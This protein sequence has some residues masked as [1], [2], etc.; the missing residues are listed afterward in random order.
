MIFRISELSLIAFS[1]IELRNSNFFS[2]VV[3]LC[4]PIPPPLLAFI[5]NY[6]I[7]MSLFWRQETCQPL[8]SLIKNAH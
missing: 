6:L 7:L 1:P 3:F 8:N 2:P 4:Y 5:A